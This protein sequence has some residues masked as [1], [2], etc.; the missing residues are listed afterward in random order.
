MVAPSTPPA[1][2]EVPPSTPAAPAVPAIVDPYRVYNF[3]LLIQGVVEGH[4]T[5]CTGLGVKVDVVK[6][7]EGGVRQVV[8]VIPG[9]VD[10][11]PVTLHYGLTAS[12]EL[13]DWL[14]TAVNGNVERKNVSIVM[15]D[16]QGENE[17]MRWNLTNAWAAAWRGSFLDAMSK[18][19]AVE[20]VTLVYEM[21]E[22]A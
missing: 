5:A 10:Y 17:V 12:R 11:E 8:R 19:I 13:F 18:E 20:S 4:F 6:Y 1:S 3:K 14:M 2:P 21:L 22:R 16:S 7:R 9:Q 15:L